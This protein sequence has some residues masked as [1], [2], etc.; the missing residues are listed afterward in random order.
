MHFWRLYDGRIVELAGVQHEHDKENYQG[1][2]HDFY[3]F[4]EL[5]QFSESIFRFV[6]GWNRTTDQGQRCRVVGAGNPPTNADGEWVIRYWA[7]WLDQ[8]HPHPALPGELRWFAVLNG[9]DSEVESSEPFTYKDELIEPK[10]R[11]FIPA[12]LKDN[13]FLMDTGYR[14]TLAAMPEPLRSQML[15]GD[16]TAG[17]QDDPWQVIPT[18]W[19][20]AAQVR[21]TPGGKPDGPQDCVGV[22]VA[23][24]GSD[25]T[26]LSRRYGAWF[27]PLEKYAGK[28][29]P[30]GQAVASLALQALVDGGQAN[31]D[32]I[33]VGASVYDLLQ[34]ENAN[35]LAVNF[36]EGSKETDRSRTLRFVNKRAECYWKLRESLDPDKGDELMLPPDSEL[37][38]DL[39]APRWSM[40]ARGIQ[41]ELKEEIV[42]RI[43][44]SPDS[45]DAVVLA[46]ADLGGLEVWRM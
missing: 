21:W 46:F 41:V 25:K 38:A 31:V 4:D 32:V 20:R 8:Q 14:A 26:V 27:A 13:P 16:F 33:G 44:R 22:D 43:G 42:H 6:T 1:R 7:P 5:P 37:L 45:G 11:T 10:S 40:R 36:A 28:S 12:N 24:G 34:Q 35:V 30:D 23:R 18:A 39:C 15:Y 9:E 19:I 3:G 29:T 17:G 2:P